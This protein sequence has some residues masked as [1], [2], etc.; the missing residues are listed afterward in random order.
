[1]EA[2]SCTL[3]GMIAPINGRCICCGRPAT[4][5]APNRPDRRGIVRPAA[6][7]GRCP[8]PATI[9]RLAREIS[10]SWDDLERG[11][12]V[13]GCCRDRVDYHRRYDLRDHVCTVGSL[14][15]ERT[16]DTG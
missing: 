13:Y 8:D 3:H 7:C 10:W 11:T 14:T 6:F 9:D 5:W 4:R 12:R 15:G 16:V 2:T 1:M